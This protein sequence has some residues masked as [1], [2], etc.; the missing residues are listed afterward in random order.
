[1]ALGRRQ[2]FVNSALG[3]DNIL[4]LRLTAASLATEVE[5]LTHWKS[6]PFLVLSKSYVIPMLTPIEATDRAM[7]D[8]MAVSDTMASLIALKK[9]RKEER[10]G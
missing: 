4:Q 10:G 1:M 5:A 2:P 3:E 8:A 7:S 9:I 6:P